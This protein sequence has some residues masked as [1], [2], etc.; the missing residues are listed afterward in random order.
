MLKPAEGLTRKTLRLEQRAVVSQEGQLA[1]PQNPVLGA[2][3]DIG[4]IDDLIAGLIH[5]VNDSGDGVFVAGA[6]NGD[7]DE[8]DFRLAQQIGW[9]RPRP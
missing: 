8:E 4:N 6:A 3:I 5:P 7:L 2:S 1:E 9:R